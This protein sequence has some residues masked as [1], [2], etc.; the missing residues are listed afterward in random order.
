ML[1]AR[2]LQR[3]EQEPAL[4]L[5]SLVENFK[6]GLEKNLPCVTGQSNIWQIQVY[7]T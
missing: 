7:T 1:S 5:L 3:K 6:I 4:K 2:T